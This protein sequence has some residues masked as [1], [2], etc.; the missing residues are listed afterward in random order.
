M[1]ALNFTYA[2][3][4]AM[5]EILPDLI[6][7]DLEDREG[8][9]LFPAVNSPTFEVRWI[10]KDS[11]GGLQQFRGLDGS[12]SKVNR[13][14]MTSYLYEPGVYSEF[15]TITERELLTRAIPTR[16]DIP[17]PVQDLIK[18]SDDQLI[19]RQGDRMEY[20]VWTLLATGTLTIPLPGPNGVTVY[21]DTY[22]IQQYTA[23]PLWSS[24]STATPLLDFQNV[25]QLSVGHSVD[26]GSGATAYMNRYTAN[27]LLRN[28]NTADFAGRRDQYGATLNN[29]GAYN[30]YFGGQ[31]LPQIKVVD[32]G[33][34][35]YPVNGVITNPGVQ[36]Q[37]F[38]PNGIVIVVGRRPNNAPVG[39]TQ[40]TLQA[41]MPG[42]SFSSGPYR[43]VKDSSRGLN[44][45][46]E[47]PP[48]IE[49]HHGW[50]GGLSI[51]YPSA[52]VTMKVA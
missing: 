42:A 19:K 43:F 16:P 4:A 21:T 47:V 3:P 17:V 27:L 24:F 35:P 38:I 22:P 52:V 7:N 6:T 40:M 34:P 45:A 36:F 11:Y 28:S 33:F 48:R 13:V 51:S 18:E 23:T 31:G 25:Q 49:V 29:V 12:P 10:Q 50:N 46:V 30:S 26:L 41:M 2:S 32:S 44:C 1:T 39:N 15:M 14:G 5:T 9:K 8:M 20:N 37:K